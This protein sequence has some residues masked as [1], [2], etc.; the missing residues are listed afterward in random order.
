MDAPPPVNAAEFKHRMSCCWYGDARI[1]HSVRPVG[2]NNLQSA[3]GRWVDGDRARRKTGPQV[4]CPDCVQAL[5]V[6]ADQATTNTEEE[7]RMTP[8]K[9]EPDAVMNHSRETRR[10]LINMLAEVFHGVDGDGGPLLTTE[11]ARVLA[12]AATSA[13]LSSGPYLVAD[14]RLYRPTAAESY[15]IDDDG[16]KWRVTLPWGSWGPDPEGEGTGDV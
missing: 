5:N 9:H 3:C 14:Q 4:T 8:S 2:I 15:D 6:L 1:I 13:M 12:L 11:D 10:D 7:T 16:W